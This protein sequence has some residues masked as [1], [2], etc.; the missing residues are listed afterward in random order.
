[1]YMD[2]RR[3]ER[4]NKFLWLIS[5]VCNCKEFEVDYDGEIYKAHGVDEEDAAT[6]WAEDYDDN[7]DHTL[8]HHGEVTISIKGASGETKR[9]TCGAE[10]VI[11]YSVS[12]IEDAT[13]PL[14][15]DE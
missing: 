8:L 14:T 2:Y 9:F 13:M 3:C 15:T 5:D 10:A 1:M 6:N 11:Q 12:E 7:G 4:C